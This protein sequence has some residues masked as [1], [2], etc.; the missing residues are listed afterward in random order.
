MGRPKKE[1]ALKQD[2][3]VAQVKEDAPPKKPK[4]KK[5]SPGYFDCTM[6]H[7]KKQGNKIVGLG[8]AKKHPKNL[9]E[10]NIDE[11]NTQQINTGLVIMKDGVDYELAD[12]KVNKSVLKMYVEK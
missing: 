10:S 2:A 12:V 8:E 11:Y 6:Y 9:H 5:L 7:L 3:K 1:D 4:A